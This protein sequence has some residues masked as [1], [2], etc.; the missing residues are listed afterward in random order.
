M[1]L[2]DVKATLSNNND[3]K[4]SIKFNPKTNIKFG[5]KKFIDWY[6]SFYLNE[7]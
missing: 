7:K 4:S 2:G 3:L 1:Q 5:I 6:K